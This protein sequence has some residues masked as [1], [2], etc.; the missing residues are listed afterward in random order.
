MARPQQQQSNQITMKQGIDFILKIC[1]GKDEADLAASFEQQLDFLLQ[2]DNNNH[3][4]QS[5]IDT[6]GYEEGLLACFALC[7]RVEGS[8]GERLLLK[9]CQLT[10]KLIAKH[11]LKLS[12]EALNQLIS[13]HL[14]FCQRQFHSK[15]ADFSTNVIFIDSIL[16]SLGSLLFEN[17]SRISQSHKDALLGISPS[18]SSS[19]RS[20]TFA[21]LRL[22][23]LDGLLPPLPSPSCP[24]STRLAALKCLRN[25]TIK[26]AARNIGAAA[27]ETTAPLSAFHATRCYD[28]FLH[29][30]LSPMTLPT[31]G[32]IMAP[33]PGAVDAVIAYAQ[34][35]LTA[36][37]GIENCLLLNYDVHGENVGHL[38]AA[39]KSFMF[40][41]ITGS[42]RLGK[43]TIREFHFLC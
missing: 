2:C 34:R 10:E 33:P 19:H 43:I 5:V 17:G 9:T 20:S 37:Q 16:A 27:N 8:A 35:Q 1:Y 31:I 38:M 6:R 25:L 42:Y 28:V 18:A 22:D 26:N 15:G 12:D 40:F 13:Q 41:G 21:Q 30:I 36:F 4:H 23:H 32:G 7:R 3:H 29:V 39:L 11:H 14:E 24:A